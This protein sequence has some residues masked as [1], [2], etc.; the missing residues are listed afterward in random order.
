MSTCMFCGN[1]IA[2]ASI[3][4]QF[5]IPIGDNQEPL[6]GSGDAHLNCISDFERAQFNYD[7][8]AENIIGEWEQVLAQ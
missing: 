8:I 5:L 3:A 4:Y 6:Q 1:E 2:H 7:D